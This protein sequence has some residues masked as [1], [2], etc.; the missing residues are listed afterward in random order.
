MT[1]FVYENLDLKKERQNCPFDKKE[2]TTLIDGSVEKTEYR[3]EVGNFS[4]ILFV[5][6]F[7]HRDATIN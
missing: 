3:R 6:V 5:L 7:C 4:Y 1:K 2:I